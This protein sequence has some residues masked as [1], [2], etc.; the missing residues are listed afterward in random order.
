VV[1]T[2][3]RVVF[4]NPDDLLVFIEHGLVKPDAIHLIRGSG[5]DL[6]TFLPRVPADSPTTRIL[7]A[8][9]MLWSKGLAELVAAADIVGKRY[10]AAVFMIAGE[11]D[12]AN[13][14]SVSPETITSWSRKK[15]VVILGHRADM[16]SLLQ[17]IDIVVLPSFYGEGVPKILLEAAASGVAAVATDVPGCREIV[18]HGVNGL[19]VPARNA[20]A[21]A[22]ALMLLI[23]NPSLRHEMG[24]RS[25]YIAQAEFSSERVTAETLDVYKCALH[26]RS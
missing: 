15:N 16:P 19:L 17:R 13:P 21:L 5:V 24:R 6:Q 10:P 1:L 3:T 26:G 23:E 9:R 18:R 25:R 11:P 22:D 4:Q 2:G 8:S 20:G 14:A 7:F 12:P